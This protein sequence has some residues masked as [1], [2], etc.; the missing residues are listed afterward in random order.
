MF[1]Q[2]FCEIKIL[3][4][5]QTKPQ[6]TQS[7]NM[8]ALKQINERSFYNNHQLERLVIPGS[9]ELIKQYAFAFNDNLEEVVILSKNITFG[10]RAFYGCE[11]L[12][13]MTIA[14]EQIEMKEKVFEK[15]SIESI[16]VLVDYEGNTINGIKSINKRTM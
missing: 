4:T 16:K 3:N 13:K 8:N 5:Q 1:D 14:S 12:K 15:T 2:I 6:M 9:V 11:K 10:E 7:L